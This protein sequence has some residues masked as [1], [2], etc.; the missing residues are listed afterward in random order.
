MQSHPERQRRIPATEG[1]NEAF[2]F[3]LNHLRVEKRLSPNSLEAYSRDLHRFIDFARLQKWGG[4]A[5]VKDTDLLSFLI[6]L[7]AKKLKGRSVARNLVTIR[8]LFSFL[9]K[10]NR[11]KKNPTGQIDF[12]KMLKKLPGFLRLFEI[13][14]M[15]AACD[16]R[17]PHGMRDHCILQLLYAAGLR[18]SELTGLKVG[19][20]NCEAGFLLAFGKG[21][22]ERV[23][24]LGR[25]ALDSFKK[26][27]EEA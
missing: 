19:H 12:P 1:W 16:Q 25:A 20:V 27:L 24:P 13:D 3:Y 17:T 8:G 26:Y 18:V 4:P 5:D 10:E 2:D 7:H 23:V 6:F 15:L 11:L 14:Q 22:R 21:S 9:V